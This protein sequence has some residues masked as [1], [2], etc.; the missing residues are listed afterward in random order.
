[1]GGM[2][3]RL[4]RRNQT[5]FFQVDPSDNFQSIKIRI[6]ALFQREPTAIYLIGPDKVFFKIYI[7]KL[8]YAL[9]L[10]KRDVRFSYRV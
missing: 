3:I 7:S 8:F 10:E 4:K 1:M 5:V 9:Y 2:Y 6:G